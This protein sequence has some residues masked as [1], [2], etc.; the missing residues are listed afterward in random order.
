MKSGGQNPP[1]L[2]LFFNFAPKIYNQ[3]IFFLFCVFIRFISSAALSILCVKYYKIT[4]VYNGAIP[5]INAFIPPVKR[6]Y[7]IYNFVIILAF[8]ITHVFAQ[9]TLLCNTVYA[10]DTKLKGLFFYPCHYFITKI[11]KFTVSAKI[12]ISATEFYRFRNLHGSFLI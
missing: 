7:K 4:L 9:V 11:I 2:S 1:L 5:K 6:W 12:K 8:E 10:S 3:L